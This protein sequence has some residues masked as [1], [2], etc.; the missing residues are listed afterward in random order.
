MR[1]FFALMAFTVYAADY[2]ACTIY[3]TQRNTGYWTTATGKI[4]LDKAVT[5]RLIS[6]QRSDGS[7]AEYL[8]L[9]PDSQLGGKKSDEATIWDVGKGQFIQYAPFLNAKT[10]YAWEP[11]KIAVILAGKPTSESDCMLRRSGGP[12]F[13][14][15]W[16]FVGR[17]Q[18][19]GF[20]TVHY[21]RE[22]HT[23]A[24]G[25]HSVTHPW[26]AT[27]L[28]CRILKDVRTTTD[29]KGRVTSEMVQ[30]P[31][32]ILLAEPDEALF[33]PKADEL[34]PSDE[35]NRRKQFFYG[36]DATDAE[37]AQVAQDAKYLAGRR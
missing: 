7:T 33:E 19:M 26:L 8:Y 24:S 29:A 2:P 20:D 15:L 25:N 32:K 18:I 17:E 12:A 3:K 30:E 31:D 10:T 23:D 6:A 16:N 4:P 37:R 22:E 9:D 11:P 5:A 14:G 21:T 13:I 35:L 28:S 34:K 36:R 1:L 27:A